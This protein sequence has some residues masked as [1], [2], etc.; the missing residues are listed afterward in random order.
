VYLVHILLPL[1][2]TGVTWWLVNF[3]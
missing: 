3:F 1:W 2:R